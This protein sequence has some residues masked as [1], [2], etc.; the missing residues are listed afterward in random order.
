MTVELGPLA[1]TF[2]LIIGDWNLW[3]IFEKSFP[4]RGSLPTLIGKIALNSILGIGTLFLLIRGVYLKRM[5]Y[6]VGIRILPYV[7]FKIVRVIGDIKSW[8]DFKAS[9]RRNFSQNP[10]AEVSQETVSKGKLLELLVEQHLAKLNSEEQASYQEK[11]DECDS[12][13]IIHISH[14]VAEHFISFSTA[15]TKEET[16]SFMHAHF[17][18]LQ[19]LHETQKNL[20]SLKEKASD[21]AMTLKQKVTTLKNTIATALHRQ[22]DFIECLHKAFWPHIPSSDPTPPEPPAIAFTRGAVAHETDR[23][24]TQRTFTEIMNREFQRFAENQRN[25]LHA[26][27]RAYIHRQLENSLRESALQRAEE[28][29]RA[30]HNHIMEHLISVGERNRPNDLA[31]LRGN[32]AQ[33]PQRTI[34]RTRQSST[35]HE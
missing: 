29:E 10:I 9:S 6:D 26:A 17:E 12:E 1:S 33:T 15:L 23:G 3:N 30:Q 27:E 19:E 21:Q 2:T 28:R 14:L 4:E 18:I 35:P 22:L 16:P 20:D 13:F 34:E 11:I 31:L 24:F 8:L 32:L 25:A 5:N 7:A